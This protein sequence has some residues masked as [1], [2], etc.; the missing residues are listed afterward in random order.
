MPD[1]FA[2]GNT[3]RHKDSIWRVTQKILGALVGSGGGGG[4]GA[5]ATYALGGNFSGSGSPEGV[6]T[7][8]PGAVYLDTDAPG[9]QYFKRTGTGNT[10]WV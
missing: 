1:F 10:G 2:E 7:A 9:T 5:S 3:P 8:S 4:S 6:V